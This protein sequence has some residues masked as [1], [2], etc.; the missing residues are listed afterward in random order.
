[1]AAFQRGT[2]NGV[3]HVH[4][5]LSP[6]EWTAFQLAPF[7]WLA[8]NDPGQVLAGLMQPGSPVSIATFVSDPAQSGPVNLCEAD[9]TG[10]I[11][12]NGPG[13]VCLCTPVAMAQANQLNAFVAT[14]FG[15]E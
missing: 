10:T 12:P 4:V 14:T 2:I 7:A 11:T 8:A 6:S 5:D 9:P 1:M 15:P 3:D 13:H